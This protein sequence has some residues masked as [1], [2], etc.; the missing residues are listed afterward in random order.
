MLATQAATI[1]SAGMPDLKATGPVSV[2]QSLP[3]LFSSFTMGRS[4]FAKI[5]GRGTSQELLAICDYAADTSS[6]V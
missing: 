6:I 3:N 5:A 2:W 4:Q 1:L